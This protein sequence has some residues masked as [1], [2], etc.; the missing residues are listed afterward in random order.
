[1][2]KTFQFSGPVAILLL[3]AALAVIGIRV[4]SLGSNSD[5]TLEAAVRQELMGEKYQSMLDSVKRV[6]KEKKVD[7]EAIDKPVKIFKLATSEPLFNALSSNKRVIVY[8]RYVVA[9]QNQ[10]KER[11]MEFNYGAIGNSWRYRRDVSVVSYYLNLL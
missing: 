6:V 4:A 2:E 3:V 8:V 7:V 5:P 11:Y 1:M 10:T 9:G